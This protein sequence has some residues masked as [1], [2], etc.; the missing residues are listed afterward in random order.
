MTTRTIATLGALGSVAFT[1]WAGR[2]APPVLQGMFAAWVIS[3]FL[4]LLSAT[5]LAAK[6]PEESQRALRLPAAILSALSIV[7][8]LVAALIAAKPVTPVF[9]LW[10]AI[11]WISA[12][13]AVARSAR[14]ARP[15]GR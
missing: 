14:L 9:V 10:P 1:V 13:I 12:G 7:L 15:Q 11:S 5:R 2:H 8:Y 3:P 6:W 4:F